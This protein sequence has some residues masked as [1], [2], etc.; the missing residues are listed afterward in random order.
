VVQIEPGPMPD[1]DGVGA[2]VDQRLGALG[3]G[4]VAGHHLHALRRA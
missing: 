3:G 2:G 1:L 4:D